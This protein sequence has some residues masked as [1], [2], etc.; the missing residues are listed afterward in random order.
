[1]RAGAA[2]KHV[3]LRARDHVDGLEHVFEKVFRDKVIVAAEIQLRRPPAV[4]ESFRGNI[5]ETPKI[6][7]PLRK[8]N[9]R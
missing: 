6:V 1:M 7:L 9:G 8:K 3:H 5:G 4:L 2:L